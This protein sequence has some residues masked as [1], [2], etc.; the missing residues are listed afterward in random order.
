M[1]VDLRFSLK[2]VCSLTGI[3]H[4]SI[5][6]YENMGVLPRI[7][8]EGNG[9]RYYHYPDL[10]RVIFLRYY[11]AS[12]VPIREAASLINGQSADELIARLKTCEEALDFQCLFLKAQREALRRQSALLQR[13]SDYD[14]RCEICMRPGLYRL[15]CAENGRIFHDKESQRLMQEWSALFPVTLF[16]GRIDS[17]S[18]RPDSVVDPGYVL[19]EE[20]AA[21]LSTLDSPRI[22]YYPPVR[23]VQS[24]IRISSQARDF[25]SMGGCQQKYLKENGLTPKG[26]ILSIS[27]ANKTLAKGLNDPSDFVLAWTEI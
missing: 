27:I 16:S 5:R 15:S 13:V 24:L 3:S 1:E 2:D 8:E 19:Y 12:G 6:T 9:Y 10:Q 22:R 18:L 17:G 14:D 11:A 4:Q 23:C 7:S 21:L 25:V 26:D 20:H